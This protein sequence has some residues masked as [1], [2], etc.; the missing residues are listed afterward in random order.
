MKKYGYREPEPSQLFETLKVASG[1]LSAKAPE[2]AFRF[3]HYLMKHSSVNGLVNEK[4]VSDLYDM[5][6]ENSRKY[7]DAQPAVPSAGALQTKGRE[8]FNSQKQP[9]GKSSSENT[10][11]FCGSVDHW[12]KDCP[13]RS[14]QPTSSKGQSSSSGGKGQPI[15]PKPK[16]VPAPKGNSKGKGRGKGDSK[17]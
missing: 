12:M 17:K 2:L 3:Q 5:L 1:A 14:T 11:Y 15:K 7:L 8:Y 16:P 10:C 13:H 4:T 9:P 6:L